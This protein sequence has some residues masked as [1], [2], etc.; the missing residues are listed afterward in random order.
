MA[1]DMGV[2]CEQYGV[3][4]A[5]AHGE[6]ERCGDVPR[7]WVVTGRSESG[8]EFVYVFKEKP[9]G[10]SLELFFAEEQPE[11]WEAGCIQSWHI[12][13]EVVR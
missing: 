12:D 8:D 3:C 1:C 9:T 13:H 6:P 10:E 7:V 5:A 11:E 2:G 4:Y